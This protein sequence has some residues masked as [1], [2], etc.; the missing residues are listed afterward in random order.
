MA[1]QS[2]TST[3]RYYLAKRQDA[4]ADCDTAIEGVWRSKQEA[5]PGT[6]LP[7]DFPHLEA[8]TAL[9]YTTEEDLDGADAAEL[10]DLGMSQR[11]ARSVISAFEAL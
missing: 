7:D 5:E 9:G 10:T 3:R 1:E 4:R 6:A 8:L 11:D 2:F